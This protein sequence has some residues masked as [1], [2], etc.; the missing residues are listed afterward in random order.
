[1]ESIQIILVIVIVS[2]TALLIIVG[3]QVVFIIAAVKRVLQKLESKIDAT[4]MIDKEF[5]EGKVRGL[6]AFFKKFKRS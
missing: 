5:V 6:R 3:I 4:D 1:M 2:L